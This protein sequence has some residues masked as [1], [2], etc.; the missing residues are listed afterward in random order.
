MLFM[1]V[2][3][4]KPMRIQGCF[5]SNREVESVVSYLKNAQQHEY[6]DKV[7]EEIDKQAAEA[8]KSSVKAGA[9]DE[10]SDGDEMLS[11]AIEIVVE[12]GSASTSMLQRRL[13]LGYARAG[14]L[15]DE[16]EQRGI[17]GPYEGDKPPGSSITPAMARNE[18]EQ[19]G[20][21]RGLKSK[22]K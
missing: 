6:D 12:A 18:Y 10:N 3:T 13:R 15:I 9:D 4:T 1:P 14:R 21:G 2:G 20:S 19:S 5:V 11:Q 22:W 16:M 8:G 7:I 17:V